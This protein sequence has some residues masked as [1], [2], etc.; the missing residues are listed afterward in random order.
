MC[1]RLLLCDGTVFDQILHERMIFGYL[2]YIPL[3]YR[4]EICSA[5]ANIYYLAFTVVRNDPADNFRQTVNSRKRPC[6]LH[7]RLL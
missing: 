5:V 2:I 4:D 3:P 6:L 1:S 7:Y